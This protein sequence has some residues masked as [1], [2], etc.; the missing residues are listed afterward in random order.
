MDNYSLIE[1]LGKKGTMA[2]VKIKINDKLYD[3]I[4][5]IKWIELENGGYYEITVEKGDL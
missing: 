3:N 4:T 1:A 5:H 2:P